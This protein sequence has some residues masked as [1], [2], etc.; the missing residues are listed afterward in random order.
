MTIID[1]L[2]HINEDAR[3]GF[4]TC[5]EAFCLAKDAMGRRVPSTFCWE[6]FLYKYKLD[7]IAAG[8]SI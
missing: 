3:M 7:Y 8:A 5:Y 6:T 1:K 4:I 2:N